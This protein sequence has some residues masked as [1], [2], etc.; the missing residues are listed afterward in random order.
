MA[1]SLVFVFTQQ[2]FGMILVET[3]KISQLTN[4]LNIMHLGRLHS[5]QDVV[6]RTLYLHSIIDSSQS[7]GNKSLR[8]L[9]NE[10]KNIRELNPLTFLIKET[11]IFLAIL[12]EFVFILFVVH[13]FRVKYGITISER[14][15]MDTSE[16]TPFVTKHNIWVG[17]VGNTQF[18][19]FLIFRDF[20]LHILFL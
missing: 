10:R 18:L 9:I 15:V 11:S 12:S 8:K 3:I 13:S 2:A 17:V 1:I 6:V 16:V 19:G 7:C 14:Y 4:S 20:P 5:F